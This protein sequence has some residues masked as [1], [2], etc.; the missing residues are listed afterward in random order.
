MLK[1]FGALLQKIYN[2]SWEHLVKFEIISTRIEYQKTFVK[3]CNKCFH[4]LNDSL[5]YLK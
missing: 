3:Q 1:M 5:K 4:Y 2:I